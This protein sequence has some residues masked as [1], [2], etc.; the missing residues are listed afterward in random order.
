[1]GNI[2]T[3]FYDLIYHNQRTKIV[4]GNKVFD[5]N[6]LCQRNL[7]KIGIFG[8]QDKNVTSECSQSLGSEDFGEEK[9]TLMEVLM[10]F[11]VGQESAMFKVLKYDNKTD[12]E[13]TNDARE[14]SELVVSFRKQTATIGEKQV[15]IVIVKDCT[16]KKKWYQSQR[17]NEEEVIRQNILSADLLRSL[18]RCKSEIKE[19]RDKQVSFYE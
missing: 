9:S 7:Q 17:N 8:E 13:R 3:T 11:E 15:L 5:E 14:G 4:F 12:M 2:G 10:S 1:M 16:D 18:K 19:L 6:L